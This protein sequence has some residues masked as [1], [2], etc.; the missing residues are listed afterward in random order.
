M[1]PSDFLDKFEWAKVKFKGLPPSSRAGHS[2]VAHRDK[3][4]YVY[5]G[6]GNSEELD[7][8]N[9]VYKYS[10]GKTKNCKTCYFCHNCFSYTSQKTFSQNYLIY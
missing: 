8:S 2:F 10:I 1:L 5:G 7:S 3:D 6:F 9:L 4:I